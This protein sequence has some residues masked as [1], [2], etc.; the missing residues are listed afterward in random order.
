MISYQLLLQ[1]CQGRLQSLLLGPHD[2]SDRFLLVDSQ[3]PVHHIALSVPEKLQ[4]VQPCQ[5]SLQP[6]SDPAAV[7]Y[8]CCAQHPRT[9]A[10]PAQHA[11]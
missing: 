5:S 1:G 9:R 10:L 11:E 7:H 2:R 6:L 8:G 3:R 4:L